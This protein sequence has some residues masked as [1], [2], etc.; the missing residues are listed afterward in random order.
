MTA[1]F[2]D[3]KKGRASAATVGTIILSFA[4]GAG[5]TGILTRAIGTYALA[6]ATLVLILIDLLLWRDQKTLPQRTV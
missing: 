4:L 6:G 1:L 5:V 3:N 2:A